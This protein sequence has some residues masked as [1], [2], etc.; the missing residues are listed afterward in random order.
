MKIAVVTV[1][2]SKREYKRRNGECITAVC[3][4]AKT[5]LGGGALPRHSIGQPL[6]PLSDYNTVHT[7]TQLGCDRV[8]PFGGYLSQNRY[9]DPGL[10][11][12]I[13]S[14]LSPNGELVVLR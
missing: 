8:S 7:M 5:T 14:S 9:S 10:R 13:D 1:D 3:R 11:E 2:G 6:A 12:P 4:R